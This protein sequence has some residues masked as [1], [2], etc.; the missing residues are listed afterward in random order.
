MCQGVQ[1]WCLAAFE[2]LERERFII[3]GALLPTPQEEADPCA[4][5]GAH[6]RLGRLACIALLLLRDLGPE[7]MPGGCRRPLHA[8]L[9]P[10]LWTL[11]APVAPGLLAAALRHRRHARLFWEGGG[12]GKACAWFAEGDEAAGRQH[13]PS[14]WQGV[15]HREG[16]MILSALGDGF[17]DVGHG[18]QGAPELGEE[19]LHQE[20][21]GGA[22]A[23]SGGPRSGARDGFATGGAKVG[24]AHVGGPDEAFH[25]GTACALRGVAGG[26]VAEA[27]AQDR[28]SFLA[29]PWQELWQGVC[30]GPGQAMGETDC[31]ADQATAV[32]DALRPGAHGG[33]LGAEGGELVTVFAEDVDLACR[34]G[35]GIFGP[36]R[37][38]RFAVLSH[39]ERMDRTEHEASIGAPRGPA[40]LLLACQA[41]RDGLSVEARAA[42]LN[43]G[44]HLCRTMGKTQKL[45]V[46]SASG[47]ETDIVGR[48]RPGEANKGR[49]YCGYLWRHGA[50][51]RLWYRGAKGHAGWRAAKA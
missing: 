17:G 32:R 25:S 8:R 1:E 19:G 31:V 44:V 5:P 7:G 13:G 6:G 10:E 12:G 15:K 39:G 24:R 41:H 20:D 43:P 9:S 29:T 42:G 2:R 21:M 23:V 48:L 16:G 22:D 14:P 35:G 51:R 28:G 49:T 3:G 33:A 30:E 46:C 36:A 18:L 47:L 50:S 27:G 4:G 45:T 34:L 37:G 11:E 26:P 38:Q 40:G